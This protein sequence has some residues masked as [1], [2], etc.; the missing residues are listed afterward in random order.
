MRTK[1]RKVLEDIS[2]YR[3]PIGIGI[4]YGKHAIVQS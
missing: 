1:C 2:H 4:F 3:L